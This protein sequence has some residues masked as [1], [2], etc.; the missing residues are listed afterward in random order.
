MRSIREVIILSAIVFLL[1]GCQRFAA[2]PELAESPKAKL[3]EPNVVEAA[4]QVE[5]ESTNA[6]AVRAV[7]ELIYKGE[8]EAASDLMERFPASPEIERLGEIIA[9]YRQINERRQLAQQAAFKEQLDKLEEF[10]TAAAN[11]AND[12][13][14]VNDIPKILVV[15][16][17]ASEF[18]NEQQKEKLLSDK[19]VQRTFEKAKTRAAKF[20]SE[21]KWIDA[22]M[23]CYSWLAIIEKNNK[24]YTEHAE[25]L[26]EKADIVA[27]FAD[28]PCETRQE[29]YTGIK[30]RMF[31]RAIDMLNFNYVAPID[32]AETASKAIKRCRLLVEVLS[33]SYDEISKT[34]TGGAVEE[35]PFSRPD[36]REVT[37]WAASLDIISA[38]IE[39][40][41]TGITKDK[42]ID[43]FEKI[44][45]LNEATVQIPP[46][47]L[48][49]QFTE[50]ALSALDPYTLIVWPKQMT[51]FEKALT[52]K[53]TGIGILIARKSGLL[54]AESLLPDTP[55]YSSGLDAGDVIEKVDGIDTKDM[56]LECAV[57]RITGPADTKVTLTVRSPGEDHTRDITI[58]R[59]E[60]TVPTISGWQRTEQG[61]WI[62]MIDKADKI[63]YVSLANFGQVTGPDL[64]KV[65]AVL[66]AEEMRGLILDLRFN[67]G[68]L[69]S[70]AIEVTD[71]FIEEG[72]I[73]STRPRFGVNT[74]ALAH[75]TK[76]YCGC[77]LVVLV[78]GGS[79][80]ASEIVSGALAD[81]V[82]KRAILVGERT[83]GKSSVQTTTPY[84][85]EGAQLKYTM[86]YWYLPSG[87]RVPN[88]DEVK[89]A[90]REDWGIAPNIEVKL[91][92]NE[93]KKML[94][95][96]RDNQVLVK[97]SHDSSARPLKRHALKESLEADPQMA[98]ALLVLKSKLIESE[99]GAEAVAAVPQVAGVN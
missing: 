99:V 43:V 42:F 85:G 28:S 87:T 11:E 3:A 4:A 88:H 54:T 59:A 18:A 66:E 13:N 67:N 15:V 47:V 60:I 65:L 19:F 17:K 2:Q 69:L 55:A 37:V 8:I 26:Y 68:G 6:S 36:S 94:D 79:A 20:E 78:N 81:K 92:S 56:T 89:K 34:K 44:L 93:I 33:A 84:P 86:A 62:Y 25:E 97:A 72:L 96:Q 27:T 77:P 40:S 58:T 48:I 29:R 14:E 80:S 98:V 1:S 46:G 51:D 45:A 70:S 22:Y 7:C 64:E 71:E 23:V 82:H 9:E 35:K 50:T 63:G 53:F 95:T 61:N 90:G 75:K 16:A 39:Q 21:G 83:H 32:Y 10:R 73:V 52:N 38:E 30:E 49:A 57:K 12:V 31:V 91:T 76:S 74:Y 24:A 5:V 41:V